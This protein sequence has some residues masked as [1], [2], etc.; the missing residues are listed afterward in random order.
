MAMFH[1]HVLPGA[2]RVRPWFNRRE[3]CNPTHGSGLKYPLAASPQTLKR[4]T[5]SAGIDV[6]E[7][8]MRR[9]KPPGSSRMM[10]GS[11]L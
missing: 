3:S 5:G 10:N 7:W 1:S 6:A 9:D 2:S 8:E 4:T 11:P